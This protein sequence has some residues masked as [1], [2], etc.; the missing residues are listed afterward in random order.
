MLIQFWDTASLPCVFHACTCTEIEGRCLPKESRFFTFKSHNSCTTASTKHL[1]SRKK[2][3]LFLTDLSTKWEKNANKLSTELEWALPQTEQ[4]AT[5]LRSCSEASP[6]VT[7]K[8]TLPCMGLP[9]FGAVAT[10]GLYFSKFLNLQKSKLGQ[11]EHH[12][13]VW[14]ESGVDQGGSIF[15]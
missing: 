14:W 2:L 6:W 5:H 3:F 12:A 13:S 8:G 10:L 4:S 9:G 1:R 11:N 15:L 7:I